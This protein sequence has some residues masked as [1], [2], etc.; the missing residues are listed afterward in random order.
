MLKNKNK[1]KTSG[2]MG[3]KIYTY[4]KNYS[5]VLIRNQESKKKME[6]IIKI[7]KGETNKQKCLKLLRKK[8]SK[9]KKKMY[10]IFERYK[11]PKVV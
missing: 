9:M 5:R 10:Q 7:L 2:E 4:E 1:E 8:H 3:E 11:L 6:R